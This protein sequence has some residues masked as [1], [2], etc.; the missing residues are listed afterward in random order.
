MLKTVIDALFS[1]QISART[2]A[3]IVIPKKENPNTNV[4]G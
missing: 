2:E 3:N 4:L 1:H